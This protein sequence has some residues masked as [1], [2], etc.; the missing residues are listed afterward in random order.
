VL[1]TTPVGFGVLT[2][3]A[4]YRPRLALGIW[5]LLLAAVVVIRLFRRVRG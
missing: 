4:L 2:P 3:I 1:T 5:L